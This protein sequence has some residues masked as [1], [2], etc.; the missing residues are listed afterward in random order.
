MVQAPTNPDA[1]VR[2]VSGSRIA[3]LR[4][5]FPSSGLDAAVAKML[6]SLTNLAESSL[7]PPPLESGIGSTYY[8]IKNHVTV[9]A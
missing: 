4:H 2:L 1:R 7:P 6:V 8:W 9:R 5:Q 3:R